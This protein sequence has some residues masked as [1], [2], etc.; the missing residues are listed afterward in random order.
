MRSAGQEDEI[1]YEASQWVKE[2]ARFAPT[3]PVFQLFSRE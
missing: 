2:I 1:D 3:E